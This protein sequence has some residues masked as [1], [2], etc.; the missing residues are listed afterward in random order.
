MPLSAC[1]RVAAQSPY[2]FVYNPRTLRT[3]GKRYEPDKERYAIVLIQPVPD[4]VC[5]HVQITRD[6]D[7]A[8][9]ACEGRQRISIARAI[10]A[11]YTRVALVDTGTY[12]LADYEPYVRTVGEFYGLPVHTLQ[13][14]L[15][16]LEKLVRGPHDAEFIVVEPGDTLHERLFW[17]PP[18]DPATCPGG[19]SIVDPANR[20]ARR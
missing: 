16:L 9:P 3:V 10:L 5:Q 13:G 1:T 20:S 8:R 6:R 18:C 14:S 15:R 17:T 11:N 19:R 4:R 7:G 2:V 12:P